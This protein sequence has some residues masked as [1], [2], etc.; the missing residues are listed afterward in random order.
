ML[1][2]G[3]FGPPSIVEGFGRGASGRLH[4]DHLIGLGT[5]RALD[6]IEL[7]LVPLAKSFIAILEDG[8][9]VNKQVWPVFPTNETIS[10]GIVE[11]LDDAL[12]LSHD[13]S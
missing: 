6:D 12:V 9:V 3:G 8:A 7:N 4:H 13:F 1:S 2:I 10:L 11:P 5:L